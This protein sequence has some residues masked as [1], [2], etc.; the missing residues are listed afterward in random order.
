MSIQAASPSQ[1]CLASSRYCDKTAK[2]QLRKLDA[3]SARRIVGFMDERIAGQDDPRNTGKAL[4]VP[5]GSLWL[6]RAGDCPV[7]CDIP[8]GAWRVLVMRIGNRRE[9]YRQGD[10]PCRCHATP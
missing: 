8:D 4:T 1:Q 7:I 2:G 6:Y 10:G 9:I 3:P 5:L